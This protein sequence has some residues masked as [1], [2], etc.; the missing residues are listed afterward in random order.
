MAF[1]KTGTPHPFKS[2]QADQKNIEQLCEICKKNQAEF[3]E[4]RKKICSSCKRKQEC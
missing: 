3:Y 4:D 1:I 2:V